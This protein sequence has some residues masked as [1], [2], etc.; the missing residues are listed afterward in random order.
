MTTAFGV[1]GLGRGCATTSKMGPRLFTYVCNLNLLFVKEPCDN[2][3]P[4]LIPSKPSIIVVEF[5]Y[6]HS[7]AQLLKMEDLVI[8]Q[9]S[10]SKE[11]LVEEE[12]TKS[13]EKKKERYVNRNL[14]S[15]QSLL[16]TAW[17]FRCG[18]FLLGQA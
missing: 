1:G 4:S 3:S 13:T 7:F 12:K 18:A 5:F 10:S 16:L 11:I 6:F 14:S 17:K 8:D 9:G 15:L 2:F